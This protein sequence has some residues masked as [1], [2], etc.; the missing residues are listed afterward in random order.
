[1]PGDL[2]A[3]AG[4]SG[5]GREHSAL[6]VLLSAGGGVPGLVREHSALQVSPAAAAGEHFSL[7]VDSAS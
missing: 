3:K 5:C 7:Q 4:V 1:M 2:L 6:Q